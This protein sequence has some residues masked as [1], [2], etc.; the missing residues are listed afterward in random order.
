MYL[1]LI[2]S[3]TLALPVRR[4]DELVARS[5]SKLPHETTSSSV[6]NRPLLCCQAHPAP[7]NEG[8]P[9]IL[10]GVACLVLERRGRTAIL[11]MSAEYQRKLG[12]VP[13]SQPSL[14][15]NVAKVASIFESPDRGTRGHTSTASWSAMINSALRSRNSRSRLISRT[16]EVCQGCREGGSNIDAARVEWLEGHAILRV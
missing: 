5:I 3:A 14:G 12:T 9:S 1:W 16:E 8:N 7:G 2:S 10:H 4:T 11:I 6:V 15:R 13:G